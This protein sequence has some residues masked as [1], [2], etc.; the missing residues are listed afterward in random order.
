MTSLPSIE[1]RSTHIMRQQRIAIGRYK[2]T[3]QQN[4]DLNME[5]GSRL[6]YQEQLFRK[7]TTKPW[8]N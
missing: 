2:N 7:N 4:R 6:P 5:R 3:P 1:S 8:N